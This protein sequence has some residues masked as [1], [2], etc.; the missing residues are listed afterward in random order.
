MCPSAGGLDDPQ[1]SVAPIIW[2]VVMNLITK[3]ATSPF[4][5]LG[6]LVG[7]GEELS[8]VDFEPGTARLLKGETNKISK[9]TKALVERRHQPGN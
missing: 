1:F 8:Y 7:G 2:K 3:A 9:L 6:A 5:L 4:K